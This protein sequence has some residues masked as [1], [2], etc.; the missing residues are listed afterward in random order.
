MPQVWPKKGGNKWIIEKGNQSTNRKVKQKKKVAILEMQCKSDILE[1]I[2]KNQLTY[3]WECRHCHHSQRLYICSCRNL[4]KT[5]LP[6]LKRKVSVTKRG[7]IS[8]SKQSQQKLE[9]LLKTVHDTEREKDKILKAYPN[10]EKRM[11]V[12][13]GIENMFSLCVKLYKES[14]NTVQIS[15]AKFFYKEQKLEC[16]LFL[17]ILHKLIS[18]LLF[19]MSLYI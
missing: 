17:I 8:Q 11:I 19:F 15:L 4:V 18:V 16:S 2:E 5:S 7:M 6:I 13:Q 10:L 12:I 1:L 9:E 14:T 3:P